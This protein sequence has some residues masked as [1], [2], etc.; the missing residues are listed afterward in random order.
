MDATG[1]L[2]VRQIFVIGLPLAGTLGIGTSA[3]GLPVPNQQGDYPLTSFP[4]SQQLTWRVVDADPQGLHCRMAKQFQQVQ[5]DGADAPAAL[6]Q[7]NKLLQWPIVA[8]FQR[9]QRL[10]AVGGN[11]GQ[12]V[13]TDNRGLPW[14]PMR[15]GAKHCFV[16][17]NSRFIR[18]VR[19]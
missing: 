5:V 19:G 3:L 4:Q 13:V 18:P 16:R 6:F 7:R 12:I 10:Q 14:L 15:A 8:S 1:G 2:T 11:R 17:A 9:G